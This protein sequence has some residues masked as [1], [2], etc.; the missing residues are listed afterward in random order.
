VRLA[1]NLRLVAGNDYLVPLSKVQLPAEQRNGEIKE[2]EP[3]DYKKVYKKDKSGKKILV[4]Q[5]FEKKVKVV[6]ENGEGERQEWAERQIFVLSTAY[7]QAQQKGL[8]KRLAQTEEELKDLLVG[9]QG[10]K[11]P[12]TMPDLEV[13]IQEILD[14]KKGDL[15]GLLNVEIE[16][17]VHEKRIRAYKDRPARTEQSSTFELKISRDE[18]AIEA[19]KATLGW[20]V[21]ATTATKKSMN[22]EKCVWKYRYQNRVERRFDDLR[23]KVVPLVPIFVQK[24]NRVEALINLLMICL[25]VCTVMEYKVSK[26][27]QAKGEKLD[28][29]YEGNPKRSTATPTAKR[30]LNAFGGISV[31]I[32]TK[33]T[34]T[35]PYIQMT[36]LKDVQLKII[37]LLG[38]KSTIY[39]DLA[40]QMKLF[41][42][43]KKISET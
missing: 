10:K 31:V 39:T 4:A 19:R 34:E 18:Q 15:G 38:F 35:P 16:E 1:S 5:G 26:Q 22:F 3:S 13:A 30:M 20:Q 37:E 36:E 14:G 23:N 9:K 2:S 41:F 40:R 7:A 8:D 11:T 33:H 12:K 17:Q 29:I 28:N 43:D 25:K 42:S 6:Y 24:D 21:Y 32:S 27:L